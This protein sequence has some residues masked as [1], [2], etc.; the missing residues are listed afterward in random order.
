M[1]ILK[2]G[3][4]PLSRKYS[5]EKTTRGVSN[6]APSPAFL[7]L[8]VFQDNILLIYFWSLVTLFVIYLITTRL[9]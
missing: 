9:C 2:P 6:S 1:I 8:N 5:S 3:L 4:Y 7:G